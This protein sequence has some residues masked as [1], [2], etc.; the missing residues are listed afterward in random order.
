MYLGTYLGTYVQCD[1]HFYSGRQ[2]NREKHD[3]DMEPEINAVSITHLRLSRISQMG[4]CLQT[5]AEFDRA[6]TDQSIC[7]GGP[8]LRISV[9]LTTTMPTTCLGQQC[10]KPINKSSLSQ[11]KHSHKRGSAGSRPEA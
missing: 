2:I 10:L 7:S 5:A 1:N 11:E 9:Q 6:Q 4:E 8:R 3:L